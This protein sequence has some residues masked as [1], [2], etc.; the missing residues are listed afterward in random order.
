MTRNSTTTHSSS[1]L[2][3]SDN[4]TYTYNEMQ[5]K[6][7]TVFDERIALVEDENGEVFEVSKDALR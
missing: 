6:I 3:N 7:I 4:T 1:L 5:V 2:H